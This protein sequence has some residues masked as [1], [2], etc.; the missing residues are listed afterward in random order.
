MT[1]PQIMI[2]E[3]ELIVAK[4]IEIS[5]RKAGY[6][7]PA[8]VSSGEEAIQQAGQLRP[9]LVLMDIRLQGEMLGVEAAEQIRTRF[10]IPV[11]YLTAYADKASLQQARRSQ[12]FGYLLKPFR[13]EE[14]HST[15][16]MALY[17]HEIDQKLRESELRYRMVSELTSDFAYSV[18]VAPDGGFVTEWITDAHQRITGFTPD[19]AMALG[20]WEGLVHPDDLP[21]VAEHLQVALTGQADVCEYRTLRKDGGVRWLRNHARPAWDADQCRVVRIDAAAQ[22]I[23]EQRQAREERERLIQE[24][25]DALS[26]VKTLKSLLPICASCKKIRDDKGYWTAV[27]SYIRKHAGVE[28][29]HGICPDCARELYP[30][31]LK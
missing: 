20:L 19:E 21:L 18:R 4:N 5:L 22:D 8:I 9:N 6:E 2:V 1:G 12:P 17:K 29:S 10:D 23:T 3:D 31:F 14:L 7:V 28:F 30:D 24:L 16:E 15:I 26:K 25:Q 11:I 13:R 27:E